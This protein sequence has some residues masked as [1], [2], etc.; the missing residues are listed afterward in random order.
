[1]QVG[2]T[3]A[4]EEPGSE[5]VSEANTTPL[6]S[7]VSALMERSAAFLQVHWTPAAQP[8]RSV[9]RTQVL[10]PRPQWFPA[11]PDYMEEVRSS[12]DSPASAPSVSK[13]ATLLSSLEGADKLSLAG[14]PPVDSTIAALVRAPLVG[15]FARDPMCPNPQCR[16]TET[17]LKR[18][19]AAEAQETRLANTASVLTM[20]LDGVLRE[21]PLPEP[22]ASGLRLLS[23]TLLQIS[24]LQGQ[25]LDRS[26]AGLI[27]ARRQL[28]LSQARVPDTD[29]AALLDAP[30]SPGHTF[31]PA[32]EEILQKSLRER[33]ASRQVAALLPPSAPVWGRSG[34]WWAPQTRTVTRTV[35]VPTAP[36][37]DLR[38]R[39]QGNQSRQAEGTQVVV[40]LHTSFPEAVF[41][42]SAL[43][44][45]PKLLRAPEGW[46]PQT[47]FSTQ[48]LQYWCACTSDAWVLTT[49]QTGFALQ[50]CSDPP[51]FRSV[52][53]TFVSDPLQALVLQEEVAALLGKQAI[54]RVDPFSQEFRMLTHRH[55]LQSVRP[56]DW[57]TTVDLWDAYFHI[58][59]RPEHRKYLRF[60]FQ[61]T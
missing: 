39:L 35:P 49:V 19:Y 34:R 59:I 17:H 28:W 8:R 1:M 11:F 61:G 60:S 6:P 7:L 37:G 9:L 42:A 5:C 14:I 13:Q 50:F 55:I 21:A 3:L 54:R 25:A 33:E 47:P 45:H 29:N 2:D 46:R 15:E 26:L 38:H 44:A 58:P 22:V 31:G 24:G 20:Y 10:A 32:V 52:L 12:W 4:E 48:Q 27:M 56:G 51:P 53:S 43:H 16:V 41:S 30:I 57:F 23:D 40:D 18:V 36:R